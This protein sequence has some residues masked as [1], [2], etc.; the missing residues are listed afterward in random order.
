MTRTGATV[1]ICI[2]DEDALISS[3]VL[4]KKGL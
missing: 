1:V 3:N 4:L 2:L